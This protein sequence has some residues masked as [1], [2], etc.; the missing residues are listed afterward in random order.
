MEGVSQLYASKEL[1][2]IDARRLYD[3]GALTAEML[4]DVF[5]SGKLTETEK[6]VLIYTIFI[7]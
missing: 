4:E 6:L 2:P 1:K 7:E 3:N 5:K